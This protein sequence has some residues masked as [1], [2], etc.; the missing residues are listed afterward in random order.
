MTSVMDYPAQLKDIGAKG[1]VRVFTVKAKDN[2]Y[3]S[4]KIGTFYIVYACLIKNSKFIRHSLHWPFNSKESV[5]RF[6]HNLRDTILGNKVPKTSNRSTE[7][8]T[9]KETFRHEHDLLLAAYDENSN[10][11]KEV[12]KLRNKLMRP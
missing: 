1:D 7:Y 6:K 10:L 12:T 5:I 3:N 8:P 9:Y 11:Q 2:A 4:G